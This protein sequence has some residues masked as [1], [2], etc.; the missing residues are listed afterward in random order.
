MDAWKRLALVS[1]EHDLIMNLSLAGLLSR[2]ERPAG[3]FMTEDERKSVEDAQGR[4]NQ[5]SKIIEILRGKGNKDFDAFQ[6]VLRKT[7]NEVWAKEIDEEAARQLKEY[8]KAKGNYY[9]TTCY[10]SVCDN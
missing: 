6:E 4:S 2:L 9:H 8:H 7:G 10:E 5:V 3:G 1:L